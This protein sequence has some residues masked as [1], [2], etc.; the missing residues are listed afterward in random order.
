M[1]IN[2]TKLYENFVDIKNI[3]N[4]NILGCYKTLFSKKG[5]RTNIALFTIIPILIFHF[6]CIILF[7]TFQKNV[8]NNKIK[9]ISYG[10][11]NWDM[12]ENY[13]KEQ[14]RIKKLKQKEKLKKK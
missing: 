12:V 5:I 2:K 9:D 7:Y 1:N 11:N 8:I 10:I 4:V 14:R 13:E 3:A 6:V